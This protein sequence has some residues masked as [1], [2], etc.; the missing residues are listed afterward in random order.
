MEQS[1]TLRIVSKN[2]VKR[3]RTR[4]GVTRVISF[5]SGK[6]GVGKTNT[7]VN[8]ALGLAR[9]GRS[10]LVFDAD[11]GLANVDV[12]LGLRV[13][14]TLHDVLEGHASLEDIII[15]G[16]EG[17]SIVPASSG[18]EEICNLDAQKQ[19]RLI[20]SVEEV[21]GTYDYLLIDTSAGISADV[22]FFNSASS[23]IFCVVSPEP[24]SI[25]DAYALIKVLSRNYG[26]RSI[27]IL[28]NN[29]STEQEALVAYRRLERATSR[30]LQINLRYLG[31]IPSDESVRAAILEQRGVL[32]V[33]PTSPA[34]RA[35]TQL[36]SRIDAEFLE[37]KVKG[38]MQFFFKQLLEISAHGS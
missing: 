24:T 18:I 1:Q 7:V 6:G 38:G 15:S 5:T 23:E 12:M 27:S 2:S 11:L 31:F 35:I 28:V 36:T 29:A 30:F 33:Y 19:A 26:E 8:V 37:R 25:T 22:M 17:I 21:A 4:T 14:A 9:L 13:E 10:V 16:P 3:T 34:S 32:E 20:E